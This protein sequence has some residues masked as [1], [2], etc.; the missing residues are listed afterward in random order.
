MTEHDTTEIYDNPVS[1]M[2]VKGVFGYVGIDV[3]PIQA[4]IRRDT[5]WK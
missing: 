4:T 1:Y 5:A 3:I 2:T